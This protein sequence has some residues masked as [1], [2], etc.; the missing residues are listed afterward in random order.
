[1]GLRVDSFRKTPPDY[2][3]PSRTHAEKG[4]AERIGKG[5]YQKRGVRGSPSTTAIQ[6]ARTPKKARPSA[7]ARPSA[8][9]KGC[10]GVS[11]D[12]DTTQHSHSQKE[13]K[14][15]GEAECSGEGGFEGL[16]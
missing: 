8:T 11:P 15:S 6:Q 1:M 10:S 12:N 5:V 16:P 9:K 4:Q 14:G 2:G 13:A 7:A 3:N